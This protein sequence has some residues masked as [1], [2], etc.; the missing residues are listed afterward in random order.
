[1]DYEDD[2]IIEKAGS[3]ITLKYKKVPN[4]RLYTL[5]N[6]ALLDFPIY[7][8]CAMIY[9]IDLFKEWVPFCKASST[10]FFYNK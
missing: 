10:V 8:L 9:E 1:M 2:W 4:S 5:K 6:E 7:N 3:C